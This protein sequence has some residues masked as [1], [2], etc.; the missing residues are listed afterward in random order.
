MI[1]PKEPLDQ[2]T[3]TPLSFTT[4]KNFLTPDKIRL[5]DDTLRDGEQMPGVAF[6]PEQKLQ[7]ATLL[8]DIG[9][10]VM[11]VAFPAVGA[12]EKKA[13]QLCV[14]AQ[15][16]GRIRRDVEILAMCRAVKSDIDAAVETVTSIGLPPDSISVLILST[17]SD[18]HLKYKLGKVFLK[19][20][21]L[22]ER[23]WLDKSVSFYRDANIK[24]I[25]SAI[26]HARSRGLRK[27]EFAAEDASRSHLDYAR[28][29]TEACIA[30]GGTRLCFSDTVGC[31]TPEAVDHYFP[32]LVEWTV[33]KG[34]E[35][36]AH[37]HNDLAIGAINCI[38]AL[39]H[40]ASHA[41]VTA[42]GI[43]ERAGNAPL[44]QVVMI[45][46]TLYGV[47]LPNFRYDRLVELRRTVERLS[48]I[49]IQPH[50][51]IVGE[52]VF[53][54]ESGIHTAGIAI[55]PAI[56]QFIPEDMVGGQR[57]F[58]FGKH[59]GSAA[60]EEVL[61]KHTEPLRKAGIEI[62]EALLKKLIDQVK[63]IREEHILHGNAEE[64]IRSHYA[65]YHALGITEEQLLEL[66]L[67]TKA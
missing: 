4:G 54:H 56:Y 6:S 14:Q 59:T 62:T 67:N 47:T 53:Y 66:A 27:V 13:I 52:G 42:C 2:L 18:L 29:W 55:N 21:G 63:T 1:E 7:I 64:S 34:V 19:Q 40:G 15:K 58:V 5:Y 38:R 48:G 25:T 23:E 8:S 37:F 43:G 9:V 49:P 20:E 60:I 41:G 30:A 17:L 24:M 45:L 10:H 31:L 26:A 32:P 22:D 33:K 28:R 51:P 57:R 61:R 65:S 12:S 39:S 35:L 36:H 44:E 46:K 3:R 11:D 16:E 50:M